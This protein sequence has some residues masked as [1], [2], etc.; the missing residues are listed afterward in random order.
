MTDFWTSLAI[1]AVGGFTAG[2]TIIGIILLLEKL[3]DIKRQKMWEK[4]DKCTT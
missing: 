1:G 3:D 2:G 4:S